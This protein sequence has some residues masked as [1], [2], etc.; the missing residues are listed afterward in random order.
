ME[1]EIVVRIVWRTEIP[2]TKQQIRVPHNGIYK[3]INAHQ[4]STHQYQ[5]EQDFRSKQVETGP[6]CYRQ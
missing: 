3:H 2:V 5:I 6:P 1:K 4:K